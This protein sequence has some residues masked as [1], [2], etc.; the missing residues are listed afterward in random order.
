[1][2]EALELSTFPPKLDEGLLYL[3]VFGPGFGESV[4]VRVPPDEWIII[5]SLLVEGPKSP[6]K[7]SSPVVDMLLNHGA[8]W[9]GVVLTHP[10]ADHAAGMSTILGVEGAGPIGCVAPYVDPP[11]AWATSQDPAT[12]LRQGKVEDA[13]AAIQY[14][15]EA[16]DTERWELLAGEA[17]NFG[18]ATLTVLHPSKLDVD[19]AEKKTPPS[20]PNALA[21]PVLV[22]WKDV[23]L[24]LGSDLPKRGWK[25]VHKRSA[26]MGLA[27]HTAFKVAHHGSHGALHDGVLKGPKRSREWLVTPF[28]RSPRLPCFDDEDGVA[29]LLTH[30]DELAVTSLRDVPAIAGKPRR[31]TRHTVRDA[32]LKQGATSALGRGTRAVPRSGMDPYGWIALG[33]SDQGEVID[34]QYGD[35]AVVIVDDPA[36]KASPKPLKKR[37]TKK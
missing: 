32:R 30:N 2:D 16:N 3:V 28:H 36:G 29:G 27:G 7:E 12:Q 31:V 24:V 20:D 22:E 21:S 25:K 8:R 33:F 34:R 17:R 10:H 13:L 6:A 1:M 19:K 23:R 35:G 14:R 18:D 11:E 37:K 15:W 26:S 4:V 5:D 9:T